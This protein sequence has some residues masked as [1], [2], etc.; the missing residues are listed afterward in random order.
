VTFKIPPKKKRIEMRVWEDESGGLHVQSPRSGVALC[1]LQGVLGLGRVI[2]TISPAK[3]ALLSAHG[4]KVSRKGAAERKDWPGHPGG[5]RSFP[6]CD[7]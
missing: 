3:R 4:F 2:V 7:G 5:R 1:A 6:T